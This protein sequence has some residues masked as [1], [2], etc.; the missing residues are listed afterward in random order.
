MEMFTK[1]VPEMEAEVF[2][3]VLLEPVPDEKDC[4]MQPTWTSSGGDRDDN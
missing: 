4:A 1:P 3:A 2:A